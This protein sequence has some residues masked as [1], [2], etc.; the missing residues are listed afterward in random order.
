MTNAP[1]NNRTETDAEVAAMIASGDFDHVTNGPEP[2]SAPK[3]TSIGA[4]QAAN[5]V[6][7]IY[8]RKGLVVVDG[9]K[10][11]QLDGTPMMTKRRTP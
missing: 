5:H 7:V 10:R 9:F 4:L 8:P 3:L 6:V 1:D 2:T 11:Y